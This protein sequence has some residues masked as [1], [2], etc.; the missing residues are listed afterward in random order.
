[1]KISNLILAA[2]A[3]FSAMA[4]AVPVKYPD[5]AK[6]NSIVH[7]PGSGGAYFNEDCTAI[8]V[9]PPLLG[10]LMVNG[11]T[12][13]ATLP[14]ECDRLDLLGKEQANIDQ[15][16]AI[17]MQRMVRL[18][19][20]I[21]ELEQN[22][23]DGLIPV[24]KSPEDLQNE[25]DSLVAQIVKE[26]AQL[27]TIQ[28]Q[29]D[30]EKFKIAQIEGGRGKFL[31][32]NDYSAM[33]KAYQKANP[34]KQVQRMILDQGFLSLNEEI[35]DKSNATAMGAVLR[36]QLVGVGEMPPMMDPMLLVTHPQLAKA[37]SAP[38]GAKIFGDVLSGSLQLS[39]VGAC[40]VRNAV[41]NANSFS[42][43]S[44]A[45]DIATSSTYSYQLQV[46]RNYTISYNI[47]ELVR[48]I[49]EQVK[50]GGFF[51][52][53]TLDSFIDNKQSSSWLKFTVTS[54]DQ[55]QMYTDDYI[56]EVKKEFMDRALAQIMAIQTGN[57]VAA[58]SLIAPGKNG[59]SEAGDQLQKCPNMYCQIGAGALKVLG[60]IFGSESATSSLLKS[61][62][63]SIN[64]TVNEMRMVP[65]YG[66]SV[67]Q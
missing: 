21:A 16:S 17:S 64:E 39:S 26:K 56:R 52:T 36:I 14:T 25:I 33:L 15:F 19:Q 51:S 53:S 22:L 63:G 28:D 57:P 62:S 65:E 58:L 31:I 35:S 8:Y 50:K 41:G 60:A 3:H 32:Q 45:N 12:P 18:N 42:A 44:I 24:G 48:Q 40:A 46:K 11:Y 5:C 49:H 34:G 61:L 13:N 27:K 54:D 9:L 6:R 38:S 1:M 47:Q 43:A 4:Y 29:D 37:I 20:R 23:Q 10:S 66:T 2:I 55:R 30:D 7:P 59:A 67:Y